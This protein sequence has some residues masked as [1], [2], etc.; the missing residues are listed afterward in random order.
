[1]TERGHLGHEK[2]GDNGGCQMGQGLSGM[3]GKIEG[4][5]KSL[6]HALFRNAK[7]IP[8]ALHAN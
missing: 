2:V 3:C 7:M 5:G 1:M 8:N 4:K 6:K